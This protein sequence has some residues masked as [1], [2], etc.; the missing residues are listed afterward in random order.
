MTDERRKEAARKM[1]AI[2][3]RAF[4]LTMQPFV[5]HAMSNASD[6][7]IESLLADVD[8]IRERA[9]AGDRDAIMQMARKYGASDQMIEMYLPMIVG[10]ESGA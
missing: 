6:E 9:E 7:Q 4:R 1:L 2:C 3:P 10:A 5:E 8:T